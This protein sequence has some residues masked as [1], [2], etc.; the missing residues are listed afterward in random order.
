MVTALGLSGTVLVYGG[1]REPRSLTLGTLFLILASPFTARSTLGLRGVLPG[2]AAIEFIAY[3]PT[4]AFLATATW[5]FVTAFPSA[6]SGWPVQRSSRA[7]TSI[8]LFA[9]AGLVAVNLFAQWLP[10]AWSAS[11]FSQRRGTAAFWPILTMM[12]APALPVLLWK[13]RAVGQAERA[14][15]IRFVMALMAGFTPAALLLSGVTMS[16]SLYS[17]LAAHRN[18]YGI[19][20]YG[21]LLTIPITTGYAIGSAQVLPASL[22]LRSALL[23]ATTRL[24]FLMVLAAPLAWLIV[25]ASRNPHLSLSAF[26]AQRGPR[27]AL[28]LL[29]ASALALYFQPQISALIALAFDRQKDV[30][31]TIASTVSRLRTAVGRR[32]VETALQS[33][34]QDAFGTGRVY[35]LLGQLDEELVS[36]SD[37]TCVLVRQSALV[38]MLEAEPVPI[39]V[40]GDNVSRAAR[41][42]P[43]RELRLL[44]DLQAQIVCGLPTTSG[45]LLGMVTVGRRD[46]ERDYNNADLQ[47]LAT[48]CSVAGLA[49]ERLREDR[50][51]GSADTAAA[52]CDRCHRVYP[53]QT[54]SC[55]CGRLLVDARVPFTVAGRYRTARRIG[56]GGMGVV[57]EAEDQTLGR[58]VALKALPAVT[59]QE[60]ARLT[61]EARTM[62]TLSHPHIA[63][64]YSLE[65]WRDT[66]ILVMEFFEGGTLADAVTSAAALSANEVQ[67]IERAML[68]ALSHLHERQLLHRDVKPSNIGLRRDR[69]PVLTD[70]GISVVASE[71]TSVAGTS[72]YLSP[73]VRAGTPQSAASDLW[74]LQQTLS[75]LKENKSD[76]KQTE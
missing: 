9:G 47:R 26:A 39:R 60:A 28:G 35:I 2:D 25:H 13:S 76:H 14:R 33:G 49:L 3:L 7:M 38:D 5:A 69:T 67:S 23:S 40:D 36:G 68:D 66:P 31:N 37:H 46:S 53:H 63:H 29:A 56:Q 74:A 17:H 55:K 61:S 32:E 43:R 51:D 65:F 41:Q 24:A 73:D 62:A 58:R 20:L 16:D 19:L 45:R 10:D 70:F 42:L 75:E 54:R 57:Y 64:V 52:E 34:V 4:E 21:G 59:R 44:R 27:L 11:I 1:Q 48:I 18:E 50:S 8:T 72:R 15:A 71:M 12:A 6:P 30:P 22:V